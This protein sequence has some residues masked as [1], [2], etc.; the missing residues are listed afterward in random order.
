MTAWAELFRDRFDAVAER[1]LNGCHL[2]VGGERYRLVEI[3]FYHTSKDHPDPFSH[4]D[5]VQLELGRWYFHRTGGVYRGGSFKGVDVS[6]GYCT[7]HGGVLVRG[8]EAADGSLI[9]GPS[10]TV[11]HL[12]AK[13]GHVKVSDLDR[14][15]AGRKVWDASSPIHL[16]WLDVARGHAVVKSGRV[17]LT[18]RRNP[19]TPEMTRFILMPY[20]YLTEPRR[21][22]KGKPYLVLALHRL[23]VAPDSIHQ[24]TGT[25]KASVA[26]YIADF[27]AGRASADFVPYQK[28]SL[29]TGDLCRLHGTWH[30]VYGGSLP[31]G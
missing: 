11:D 9:D 31:G 4:L 29:S 15:I 22:A 27:E 2:V 1:L 6:F 20:R 5:P 14:A 25:P 3:E 23:G 26:R 16:E 12:L 13:S 18:L 24:Q 17:G 19:L 21:T 8:I 28:D 10:V 7:A 30:A